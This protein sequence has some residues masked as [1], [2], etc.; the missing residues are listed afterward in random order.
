MALSSSLSTRFPHPFK[1]SLP[2]P[3]SCNNILPKTRVHRFKIH[4]NLGGGE[5]EIKKGGKKKFITRDQEPEQ[6]FLNAG[7]G[8]QQ[9]KGKGR[10]P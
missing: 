9:E 4:A 2:S 6:G 10:I 8:K 5:E 1:P 3:F 7:I